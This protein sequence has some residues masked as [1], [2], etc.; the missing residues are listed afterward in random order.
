[1]AKPG[2]PF[3]T[4]ELDKLR[5]EQRRLLAFMDYDLVLKYTARLVKEPESDVHPAAEW[6]IRL[7]AE[8]MPGKADVETLA[9][10]AERQL[11]RQVV[12][13]CLDTRLTGRGRRPFRD[14]FDRLPAREPVGSGLTSDEE[15][16]AADEQ[17]ERMEPYLALLIL[18]ERLA[19]DDSRDP[20]L[21]DPPELGS[22]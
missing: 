8:E 13:T 20:R 5:C 18:A 19:K 16:K 6:R 3:E 1:M 11:P 17:F 12:E 21:Q 15:V 2:D 4:E 7:L 9:N 22:F 14:V 10:E